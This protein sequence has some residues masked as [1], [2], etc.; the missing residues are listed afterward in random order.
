MN[1]K[2]LFGLMLCNAVA[3]ILLI[4][5]WCGLELALPIMCVWTIISLAVHIWVLKDYI[6]TVTIEEE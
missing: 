3:L 1:K 2:D 6:F 5:H 4:E